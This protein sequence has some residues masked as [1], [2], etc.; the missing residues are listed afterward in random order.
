MTLEE[1]IIQSVRELPEP[2]KAEVLD[3]IQYLRTK[4]EQKKRKDWTDFSLS[5]AMRGMEEEQTPYSLD[6]LKEYF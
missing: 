1:I 6:D 4:M 2:E 5:S 3:Y